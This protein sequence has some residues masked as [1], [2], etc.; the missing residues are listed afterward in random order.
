MA[1]ADQAQSV[2]QQVAGAS[3]ARA[4]ALQEASYYRAKL[5]AL[6]SGTPGDVA[7]VEKERVQ[8]LEKKLAEAL[9]AKSVLERQVEES[10]R[11]KEHQVGLRSSAEEHHSSALSRANAAE[12][13]YSRSLTDY[14]DLQRRANTHESTIQEHFEQI[15]GLTS[16][17]DRLSAENAHLKERAAASDA[18]LAKYVRTLEETQLALSAATIRNDETH[19]IW[20]D[21][22]TSLAEHQSRTRAL[23][24][25]LS[26]KHE[27]VQTATARSTDLER[28][29]KVTRDEHEA[30]KILAAGGLADLVAAHRD[31]SLQSSEPSELHAEQMKALEM[32]TETYRKMHQE[33]RTKGEATFAELN[34]CRLR[35][36]AL[37]TQVIQLRSE[38]ASLRSQHTQLAD[39]LSRSKAASSTHDL[40]I[41]DA[42]RAKEAAE[43][44]SSL[45]RNLLTDHGL[46]V[47]D[48]DLASRF[49]PMNGSESPEQ[50]H[51]RVQELEVRLEQQ[52]RAQSQLEESH[53]DSNRGLVA[54][55]QDK[56]VQLD[57]LNNEVVR[58]RGTSDTDAQE[59]E[60]FSK[61]NEELEALQRRHGHLE[62]THMKAVQYV[63]G[64]EKM[65]RRMKEVRL[66]RY[67][68]LVSHLT[69]P[70]SVL[71]GS[72][73]IQGTK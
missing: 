35:E 65:V 69:M 48:E 23:E 44:K 10:E 67:A 72:H 40:A 30:T 16:S 15:A 41:R 38:I 49:P 14:A 1:M 29:L 17:A 34:D 61:A 47:D 9:Q 19:S 31:G 20:Q 53:A 21:S 45:L 32:E 6:E 50:L 26:S 7:R 4:A 58:L 5:A 51:R 28:V 60:R 66:F 46:S 24:A 55:S 43:V 13:S 22:Q 63:K 73:S 54:A 68:A 2:D 57:H 37:Q 70:F 33:S 18:S 42:G 59:T 64:T 11:E 62:Q 12:S 39:D 3:R 56:Q 25:E 71:T 27:E 36:V 8:E 52:N